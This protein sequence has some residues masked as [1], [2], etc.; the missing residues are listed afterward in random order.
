MSLNLDYLKTMLNGIQMKMNNLKKPNW[1]QNDSNE[2]DFIEGRTHYDL[3]GEKKSIII[4]PD[5]VTGKF[6]P[7]L[8][9]IPGTTYKVSYAHGPDKFDEYAMEVQ[10]IDE[11]MITDLCPNGASAC[12]YM[13]GIAVLHYDYLEQ[14]SS[15]FWHVVSPTYWRIEGVFQNVNSL[16]TKYLD[17]DFRSGIHKMAIQISDNQ[18]NIAGMPTNLHND[19]GLFSIKQ[20]RSSA[21]GS[22]SAALGYTDALGA[23]QFTHGRYNIEDESGIYA[24]VVGNGT[25]VNKRSNAHTLDW[26]GNAWFAGDVYTGSTSGTNKDDGSKKLATEEY[27][28]EKVSENEGDTSLGLTGVSPG[29]VLVVKTVDDNGKPLTWEAKNISDLVQN[30]NEVSY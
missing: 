7:P 2:S 3:G 5:G 10:A 13:S 25:Q 29:Q 8:P 15:G 23:Y 9:L 27:V 1:N 20:G 28:I 4:K 22:D 12:L 16:N 18:E 21:T 11:S 6:Y 24:C 17:A 19:S 26:S 14:L 30:G